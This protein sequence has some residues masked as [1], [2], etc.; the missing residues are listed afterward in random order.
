MEHRTRGPE[1]VVNDLL[2]V[3]EN[4]SATAVLQRT[5]N[6]DRLTMLL[7]EIADLMGAAEPLNAK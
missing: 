6:S 4:I 5:G 3:V 1:K 7:A 2:A